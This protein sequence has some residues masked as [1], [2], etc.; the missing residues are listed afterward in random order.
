MVIIFNFLINLILDTPVVYL[1][2]S[3]LIMFFFYEVGPPPPSGGLVGL[4]RTF[5]DE[6]CNLFRTSV[7]KRGD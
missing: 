2:S 1:I 3:F 7:T 6:V 5:G 4:L